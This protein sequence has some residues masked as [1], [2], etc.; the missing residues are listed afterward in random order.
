MQ[1]A[2]RDGE[3]ELVNNNHELGVIIP[4]ESLG[5]LSCL[6][7]TSSLTVRGTSEED[8]EKQASELATYKRP[9]VKV[10]C[11]SLELDLR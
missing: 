7:L 2:S 9:L 5:C 3:P 11:S 6:E 1:I 10:S 8:V 4:S